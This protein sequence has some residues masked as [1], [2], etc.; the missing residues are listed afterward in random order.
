MWIAM[1]DS[2]ISIVE[3]RN[4]P[5]QLVVRSRLLGDL[6]AVFPEYEHCV[7]VS[8]DSDY[9][10]RLF[11][12]RSEVMDAIS[13]KIAHIEYD[14]FKNS[15]PKRQPWR[16]SAYMKI[17]G[18]MMSLQEKFYPEHRGSWL[19]YRTYGNWHGTEK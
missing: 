11:I 15:I 14:N 5:D 9:R 4:D 16:Y 6:L 10:F 12:P 17:W 18:I 1:N 13:L 2:F 8:D 7:I 19:N 3:D